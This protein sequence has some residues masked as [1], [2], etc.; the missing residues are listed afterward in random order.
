LQDDRIEA[1][2]SLDEATACCRVERLQRTASERIAPQ[3]D[4]ALM[5][6]EIEPAA[7]VEDG[8]RHR[9]TPR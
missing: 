6:F 2:S 8:G 3:V 7:V 5:P 4:G 1:L 9:K